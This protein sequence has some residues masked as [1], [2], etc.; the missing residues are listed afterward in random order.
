MTKKSRR[1]SHVYT[2]QRDKTVIALAKKAKATGMLSKNTKLHGGKYVSR[3]TLAKVRQLKDYIERDYHTVPVSKKMAEELRKEGLEVR[4]L[5]AVVAPGRAGRVQRADLKHGVIT[6]VEDLSHKRRAKVKVTK[7]GVEEI[8]RMGEGPVTEKEGRT[9]YAFS[10]YGNPHEGLYTSRAQLEAQLR[11]YRPEQIEGIREYEFEEDEYDEYLDDMKEEQQ[12]ADLERK[13]S[14]R[15]KKAEPEG[16]GYRYAA[17]KK[18]ERRAKS[19]AAKRAMMKPE[20]LQTKRKA[21]AQR[22]KEYRAKTKPTQTSRED[23]ARRSREYRAR[24][25]KERDNES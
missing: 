9:Y 12:Q 10:V 13:K 15:V 16:A 21:E 20:L 3:G 23:N 2:T 18:S 25:K 22:V 24:R 11:K 6:G 1:K 19:A 4:G 17:R 14:K 7:P 8:R 5:R